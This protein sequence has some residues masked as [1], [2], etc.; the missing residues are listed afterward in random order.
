MTLDGAWDNLRVGGNNLPLRIVQFTKDAKASDICGPPGCEEVHSER[1]DRE[2]LRCRGC[3]WGRCRGAP[4]P[5]PDSWRQACTA[6]V[7]GQTTKSNF[8]RLSSVSTVQI[9]H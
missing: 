4:P 3:W 2:R 1:I 6:K 8:I 5:R 7:A 9:L